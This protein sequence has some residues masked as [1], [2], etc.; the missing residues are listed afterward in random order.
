MT[1]FYMYPLQPIQSIQSVTKIYR[2]GVKKTLK[3]TKDTLAQTKEGGVSSNALSDEGVVN[4]TTC[5][6]TLESVKDR[7][8]IPY[9]NTKII[10]FLKKIQISLLEV[11]DGADLLDLLIDVEKCLDEIYH[12]T[13]MTSSLVLEQRLIVRL[14]VEKTKLMMALRAIS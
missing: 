4:H 3:K 9:N 5:L 7:L 11:N 14:R 1:F 13:M 10:N 8:E 6:S 12:Q 2:R